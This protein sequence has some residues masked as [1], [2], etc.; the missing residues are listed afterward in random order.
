MGRRRAPGFVQ[1]EGVAAQHHPLQHDAVRVACQQ[2]AHGHQ[3]LQMHPRGPTTPKHTHKDHA[4][5]ILRLVYE[6]P[7]PYPESTRD[8]RIRKGRFQTVAVHVVTQGTGQRSAGTS[9]Q[10]GTRGRER[11]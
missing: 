11:G 3:P 9:R 7:A 1:L 5:C 10:S 2:R 4:W 6:Y 8:S